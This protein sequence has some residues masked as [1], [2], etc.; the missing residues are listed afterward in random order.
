MTRG[1]WS[2]FTDRRL[3]QALRGA[4]RRAHRRV[5]TPTPEKLSCRLHNAGL[6]TDVVGG[7]ALTHNTL[8]CAARH[9]RRSAPKVFPEMPPESGAF[10]DD[11]GGEDPS[12][13]RVSFR[14]AGGDVTTAHPEGE[15]GSPTVGCTNKSSVRRGPIDGP[16]QGR[17]YDSLAPSH[18]T[19][20]YT[21]VGR[22]DQPHPGLTTRATCV[23]T[24]GVGSHGDGSGA[25]VGCAAA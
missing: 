14:V 9:V 8:T 2:G 15:V 24:G 10:D 16:S 4:K 3:Q 20:S 6:S 21:V 7:H 22:G 19:Q 1:C 25:V 12:H 13:S 17:V 5:S 11:G 18:P 23:R